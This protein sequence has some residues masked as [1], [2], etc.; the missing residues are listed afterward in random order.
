MGIGMAGHSHP[1]PR[2]AGQWEGN[3]SNRNR[4]EIEGG[5]QK[6]GRRGGASKDDSGDEMQMF[7]PTCF[8]PLGLLLFH[9]F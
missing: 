2:C 8:Y 5:G 4:I 6:R 3:S 9:L 1:T 7:R